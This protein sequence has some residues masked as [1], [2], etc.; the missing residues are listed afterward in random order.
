MSCSRMPR[1]KLPRPSSERGLRPRK[2]RIRGSALETRRARNSYIRAPRNVT[3]APTAIP[4]RTL[5]C[6]IDLRALRTWARWPAIVVSSSTA[7]SSC[8]DSVFASPTPML[9]VIFSMRGACMIESSPSPCL[10]SASTTR[11]F[12]PASLPRRTCTTSPF[13]IFMVWAI[14]EHLR[15][16]ADD[17]H[18]VLLAQLARDG[19]EDAGAA[20]VALLVDD[21]GGV[22]V[23]GDRRAVVA[24]ERLLRPHDHCAYDLAL[25]DGALRGRRL[26]SADDD[27]ADPSVAAVVPAD[28]A[29][30]EELAG[31]GVVGHPE[32][33]LLLDHGA[34]PLVQFVLWG[35]ENRAVQGRREHS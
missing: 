23:E 13:R 25:L 33:G 35:G 32:T 14:S 5:N 31:T 21:H 12:L 18:E 19:P 7:E 16:K 30:A 1:E 10:G 26:D 24:A 17:L 20:R 8:F 11:P 28:D 34:S 4:S 22:L 3:R 2:S 9:S 29:D 27:V 6:A 15:G